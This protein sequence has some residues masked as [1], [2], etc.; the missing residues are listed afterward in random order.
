MGSKEK[1]IKAILDALGEAAK[2]LTFY[3]LHTTNPPTLWSYCRL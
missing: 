3:E 1:N 2:P